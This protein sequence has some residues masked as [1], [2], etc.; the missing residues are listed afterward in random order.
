MWAIALRTL[1]GSSIS[2]LVSRSVTGNPCL[3]RDSWYVSPLG[4]SKTLSARAKKS[5]DGDRLFRHTNE[6]AFTLLLAFPKSNGFL[7]RLR[8]VVEYA[9]LVKLV[10]SIFNP[11]ELKAD[12]S[13]HLRLAF[14]QTLALFD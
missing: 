7:V 12:R 6:Q 2:Q 1:V 3:L 13:H 9:Y 4:Q 11:N 14:C 10:N 5:L 8:T